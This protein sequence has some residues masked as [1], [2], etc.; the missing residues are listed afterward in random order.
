MLD[1]SMETSLKLGKI[2]GDL[3]NTRDDIILIASSDF[4]HYV[5]IEFAKKYD[6][7]AIKKVLNFDVEGFYSTIAEYGLSICG[8]GPIVSIATASKM[9]GSK[10]GELL[11]YATSGDVIKHPE[12]VGYGSVIFR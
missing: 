8:V 5:P 6:I 3:L 2:L 1:Q 4:S 7:I 10:G 11:S 12:V 9:A